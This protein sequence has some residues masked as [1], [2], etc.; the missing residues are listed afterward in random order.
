MS[1]ESEEGQHIKK[2]ADLLCQGSTLTELACPACASPLF[3]LKTGGIWCARCEKRVIVAKEG[4]SVV[5]ATESTTLDTLEQT[6]LA[7][8]QE[9][10]RK[11]Q[12]EEDSA[13]LQKLDVVLSGLLQNL[14]RTRKVK[15][16]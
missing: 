2:M 9:I 13:E 7:K 10:Q 15:K 5:D 1:I 4:K 3:R 8:I 6:L 16:T 11:M 14:E 12:Q